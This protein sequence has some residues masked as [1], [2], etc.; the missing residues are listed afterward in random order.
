MA[1]GENVRFNFIVDAAGKAASGYCLQE[2]NH[3]FRQYLNELKIMKTLPSKWH[4]GATA[5]VKGAYY[6]WMRSQFFHFQLC[7]NN[8]KAEKYAIMN[9]PSWKQNHMKAEIAAVP[10]TGSTSTS[11]GKVPAEVTLHTPALLTAAVYTVPPHLNDDDYLSLPT[12]SMTGAKRHEPNDPSTAELLAKR[13]RLVQE[14]TTAPDHP[15][16]P[17]AQPANPPPDVAGS[18][19]QETSAAKMVTIYAVQRCQSPSPPEDIWGAST[20]SLSESGIAT[21]PI[22]PCMANHMHISPATSLEC[23]AELIANVSAGKT[24]KAKAS[25]ATWPPA[26]DKPKDICG[27]F[28]AVQNPTK[29]KKDYDAHYMKLVAS[30]RKALR[31]LAEADK[32]DSGSPETSTTGVL[33]LDREGDA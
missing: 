33:S 16:T 19:V 22:S 29:T 25:N 28:W 23:K 3:A 9:F 15:P 26:G 1:M 5:T 14:H 20:A 27:R 32:A 10:T 12:S 18:Q 4:S 7:S 31:R 24:A 8:W 6:K 17:P 21:V 11:K 2:I 30:E 13:V